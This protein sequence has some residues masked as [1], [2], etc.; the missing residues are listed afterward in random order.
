MQVP[1]TRFCS[2]VEPRDKIRELVM[3]LQR[4]E[5]M[6]WLESKTE[7]ETE[8][9]SHGES[10]AGEG[11][12]G[13]LAALLRQLEQQRGISL[14]PQSQTHVQVA[15]SGGE[16]DGKGFVCAHAGGEAAE[17]QHAAWRE[18]DLNQAAS[19]ERDSAIVSASGSP[20]ASVRC[21]TSSQKESISPNSLLKASAAKCMSE[22]TTAEGQGQQGLFPQPIPPVYT[23]GVMARGWSGKAYGGWMSAQR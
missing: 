8:I 3:D 6:G 7:G 14:E 5:A 12:T 15:G 4:Q 17:R 16:I 18:H 10:G 23:S 11:D 20:M 22:E 9:D 1:D 21:E 13:G 19:G 2:A